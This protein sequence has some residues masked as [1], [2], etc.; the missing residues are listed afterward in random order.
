MDLKLP[1]ITPEHQDMLE[2][3]ITEAEVENAL[4]EAHEIHALVLSGQTRILFK[5][6]FHKIL[7]IFT[8]AV[9]QLVFNTELFLTKLFQWIRERKVI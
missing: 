5:H 6:L 9:D 2:E 7:G 3:E 4:S 8:A 1:Q